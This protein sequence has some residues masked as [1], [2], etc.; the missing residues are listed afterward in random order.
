MVKFVVAQAQ[1]VA[2]HVVGRDIPVRME[3]VEF[4][5]RKGK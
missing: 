4:H 2:T 1:L 3:V 5:V